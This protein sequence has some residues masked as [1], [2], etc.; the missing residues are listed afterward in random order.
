MD[1]NWTQELVDQVDWHWQ[2]HLRPRFTGLTDAEYLWEP[3]GNTGASGLA[4]RG[5]QR[6]PPAAAT[7][8]WTS[9]CPSRRRHP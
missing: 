4:A 1:I 7:W 3:V 8:S 2:H 6:C 5:G 9:R